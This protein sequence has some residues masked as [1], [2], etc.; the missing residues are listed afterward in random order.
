MVSNDDENMDMEYIMNPKVPQA[1]KICKE[2][3][4][5]RG[6]TFPEEETGSKTNI[7]AVKPDGSYICVFMC[8]KFNSDRIRE[9]LSIM[10]EA[11]ID[12]SI[13]IYI[14]RI[15]PATKKINENLENENMTMELFSIDELQFN[16]TKHKLQPLKFIK[17]SKEEGTA[18][19]KRYGVKFPFILKTDA[20]A[21]FY[22]YHRG[23][24][25]EVWRKNGMI[26][27]RIVK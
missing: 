9:Y 20:I 17:L 23:D 14:D 7:Y 27:Y 18:F 16:I 24:V 2:M 11:E 21:R 10:K 8:L 3:M 13:V 15:T 6:Y 25:I 4:I 1:L 19:K 5:Q 26:V 12:H 22:N